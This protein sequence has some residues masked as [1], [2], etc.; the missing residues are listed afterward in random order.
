MNDERA[1]NDAMRCCA[2]CRSG[3]EAEHIKTHTNTLKQAHR[4]A[5]TGISLLFSAYSLQKHTE[6]PTVCMF[7][8]WERK[9]A[10]RE[11]MR[12]DESMTCAL[13]AAVSVVVVVVC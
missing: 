7:V 13:P 10:E 6:K 5:D 4:L 3:S 2:L 11:Q 1:T 8:F 9:R 12:A